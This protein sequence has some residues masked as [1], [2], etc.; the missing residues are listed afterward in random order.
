M[1]G[2]KLLEFTK[3]NSKISWQEIESLLIRRVD[4]PYVK[5]EFNKLQSTKIVEVCGH[6]IDPRDIKLDRYICKCCGYNCATRRFQVCNTCAQHKDHQ[7]HHKCQ[8]NHTCM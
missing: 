6:V 8:G 2:N 3:L 7:C 1:D 4:R 5:L